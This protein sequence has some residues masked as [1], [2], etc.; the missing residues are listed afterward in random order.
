M[1]QLLHLYMTTGKT[2]TL[3][4]QIFVAV[5]NKMTSDIVGCHHLDLYWISV[6]LHTIV[7]KQHAKCQNSNN[8][9]SYFFFFFCSFDLMQLLKESQRIPVKYILGICVQIN[10]ILKG[11]IHFYLFSKF[12]L[13]FAEKIH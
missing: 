13:F 9:V 8:N 12:S 6:V 4:I 2:I 5:K 10:A 3:T 1:V 11:K 7:L